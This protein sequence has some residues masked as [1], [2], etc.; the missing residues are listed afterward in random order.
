M[1]AR[2]AIS[3]EAVGASAAST[4]PAQNTAAPASITRL[5]PNSSAIM[6]KASMVLAKVSA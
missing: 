6:P 2:P 5:R 4:E 3:T 1:T